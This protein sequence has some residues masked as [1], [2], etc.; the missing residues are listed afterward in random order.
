MKHSFFEAQADLQPHNSLQ[1]PCIASWCCEAEDEGDVLETCA[2]ARRYGLPLLALGGGSNLL[3][4]PRL[5]AVVLRQKAQPLDWPD[6][7]PQDLTLRVSAGYSWTALVED[8]TQRGYYG[9]ENLA[10]IPGQAGA[11]PIQNIGAYGRE[12]KEVLVGVEGYW[13][14]SQ[15][16]DWIPAQDC[17]F[18]YRMSRFKQ[19]WRQR[20]IIT[21]VHIQLTQQ[22]ELNLDYADLRARFSTR[23]ESDQPLPWQLAQIISQIR[24]EKLPDPLQLPNA[25]SFF[26]NPVV[27]I[28]Q[29]EQLR[30]LWPQLPVYPVNA[31][32]VKLAAGWLIDQSGLKGWRQGAFA[33]HQQQA[34]VLVHHGGGSLEELLAFASQIQQRVA[35]R[36][37]VHLEREPDSALSL[38]QAH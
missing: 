33:V 38:C 36:F 34:L 7:L 12:I 22:G 10:L 27:S 30:Q 21:H 31:Q 5:E 1:L 32:Q 25:G 19:D 15:Q 8:T 28:E 13:V 3:L 14:D 17:A 23:P 2:L 35:E 9:L 6:P 18:A 29:A 26:K 20:F 11:A 16:R 24:R 4:P 37:A